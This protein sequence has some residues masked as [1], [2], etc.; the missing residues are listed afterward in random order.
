MST[1]F[2]FWTSG[3][4]K[5]KK[6]KN[7]QQSNSM[8][9]RRDT[10]EMGWTL[11]L[12]MIFLLNFCGRIYLVLAETP[13]LRVH[14]LAVCP[15]LWEFIQKVQYASSQP[16]TIDRVPTKLGHLWYWG[17]DT[18]SGVLGIF[19]C[20]ALPATCC[21]VLRFPWCPRPSIGVWTWQGDPMATRWGKAW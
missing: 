9:S 12:R 8:A 13:W 2:E 17:G 6:R 21:T 1:A 14:W 19:E 7:S 4:P 15:S 5:P 18:S 16:L 3:K 10:R 20:W 11:E